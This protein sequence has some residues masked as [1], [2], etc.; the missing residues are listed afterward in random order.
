MSRR[1][2]KGMAPIGDCRRMSFE[3]RLRWIGFWVPTLASCS[4]YRLRAYCAAGDGDWHKQVIWVGKW[5]DEIEDRKV[6]YMVGLIADITSRSPSGNGVM[7]K[8][9]CTITR[10]AEK[11]RKKQGA[12]STTNAGEGHVLKQRRVSTY[13]RMPILVDD[14]RDN[15]ELSMDKKGEVDN[16]QEGNVELSMYKK[17]ELSLAW[18]RK[19]IAAVEE[20]DMTVA[21]EGMLPIVAASNEEE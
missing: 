21:I 18:I 1:E 10:S 9:F 4:I 6:E 13:F 2:I 19:I 11:N 12:A 16:L 14:N 7:Q 8:R 15:V 3:V 20:E 5:E 17:G